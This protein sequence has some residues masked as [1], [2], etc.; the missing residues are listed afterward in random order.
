MKHITTKYYY[1]INIF[2]TNKDINILEAII[3]KVAAK[4]LYGKKKVLKLQINLIIK[5]DFILMVFIFIKFFV[6]NNFK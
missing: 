1:S 2:H 3:F 4:K 6:M 5:I